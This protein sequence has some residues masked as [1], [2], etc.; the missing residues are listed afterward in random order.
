MK[1]SYHFAM[2]DQ[3][4]NRATNFII[5]EQICKSTYAEKRDQEKFIKTKGKSL[6]PKTRDFKT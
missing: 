4:F 2:K 5:I 1:V 3:T 6:D